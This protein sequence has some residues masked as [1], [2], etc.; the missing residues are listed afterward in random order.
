M[1]PVAP[2]ITHDTRPTIVDTPLTLMSMMGRRGYC[3]LFCLESGPKIPLWLTATYWRCDY[4]GRMTNNRW[5]TVDTPCQDGV[6]SVLQS[7]MPIKAAKN[8]FMTHCNL[9]AVWLNRTNDQKSLT[10]CW[11]SFSRWDRDRVI[12]I[13]PE[14]MA[15]TS[16]MYNHKWINFYLPD[17][18]NLK[19]L[20]LYWCSFCHGSIHNMQSFDLA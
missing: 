10:V 16:I 11:C 1:Q 12:L 8:S 5:R 17:L 13:L 15:N 6:E 2:Q 4:P 3:N 9:S 14:K 20:M 18:N 7:V 19:L